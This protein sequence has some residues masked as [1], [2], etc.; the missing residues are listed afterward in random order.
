MA[1][2]STLNFASLN[3]F[4]EQIRRSRGPIRQ[5]HK[6]WG[7]T[8]LEF[9]RR[10]FL[11]NSRGGRRWPAL[12]DSTE[13]AKGRKKRARRGFKGTTRKSAILVGEGDLLGAL[14][15]GAPGNEFKFISGGVIVGYNEQRHHSGLTFRQLAV[16]HEEGNENRKP[17]PIIIELDSATASVFRRITKAQIARLGRESEARRG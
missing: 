11:I 7:L 3:H 1:K 8:Y 15:P 10:E 13:R 2:K 14:K 6:L 4:V 9:A 17:R 5:M 16:E 12:K